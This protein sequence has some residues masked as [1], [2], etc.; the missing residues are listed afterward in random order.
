MKTGEGVVLWFSWFFGFLNTPFAF[1]AF[2]AFLSFEL[3]STREQM[4]GF[5]TAVGSIAGA[6]L[7]LT[8]R[9]HHSRKR[10]IVHLLIADLALLNVM[11]RIVVGYARF[12]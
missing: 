1:I 11:F 4:L 10:K 7:G 5:L 8:A 6:V 3:P 12:Y 2:L 9:S